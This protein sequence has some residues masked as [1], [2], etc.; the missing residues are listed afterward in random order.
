M[1]LP[2]RCSNRLFE[3]V[4]AL[5]LFDI[6]VH[7]LIWPGAMSAS[8]FRLI[9]DTIGPYNLIGLYL[10]VG[11]TRLIALYVNG[12]APNIGPH[13]RAIGSLCGA[14]I[15][16]QMD[17]ALIGLPSVQGTPPSPGIQFYSVLVAAELYS[18]YRAAADAKS[19]TR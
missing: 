8:A 11:L 5:V 2:Q 18:T 13:L 3:W 9:F 15:W 10:T 17:I 4:M 16:L 1:T 14:M 19:R 7:M 12:M 6:G